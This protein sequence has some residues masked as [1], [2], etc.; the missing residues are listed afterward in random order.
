MSEGIPESGFAELLRELKNRSGHSYGTLAK[1]LHMSTSTL[2]RYC[3]GDA[4]PTDYAPVERLAR[5]CKATPGELVELHRRW[6][7]ADAGRGR[8]GA[9]PVVVAET[10]QVPE[11]AP[12]PVAE[13]TPEVVAQ[14]V[15]E[16]AAGPE[17]EPAPVPVP[18]PEP[19]PASR[20]RR[21]RSLIAG[22]RRTALLAAVTVTALIVGGTVFALNRPS[23]E[24]KGRD[25]A[26]ATT[27]SAGSA[28]VQGSTTYRPPKSGSPSPSAT[29]SASSSPSAS[30]SAEAR[31]LAPDT[32]D[33][34]PTGK[35][36]ATA[37]Q[38]ASQAVPLTV[39][40]NPYSWLSPCSQHYLIDRPPTAV[41]PPPTEPQAPAWVAVNKA[42]SAGEQFIT[43]TVQGTG[44]QTV[45]LERLSV[46]VAGKR[47]PL[48]WN[49]YAMGYPGVGCGGDVPTHS[50][51][52]SLDAMRPSPVPQAGGT[53]FP[54]KVSQSDPEVFYVMAD[55][56]AY[57]VSWY[58]ELTWSSGG[59]HGTL[60]IDDA[61]HPFRTSGNNSRPAY[62]FPL[63]GQKWKPASEFE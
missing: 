9:E 42:V 38:E 2:H 31:D 29:R 28:L 19:P 53:N 47:S 54:F 16:A 6:V 43:F 3:N 25:D 61:G 40:T 62:A 15:P 52:V 33:G 46:R 49:D 22:G 7:L 35:P 44:S 58:L 14:A 12:E 17:P 18:V 32:T 63:G 50:F 41:G 20:W 30:A 8:K 21:S 36:S 10:E 60:L 4:V 59:R 26:K 56:S 34:K 13:A 27:A 23:D 1:R 51:T 5:L 39:N 24:G 57:D 55:A 11:A 48:A 37:R 45:V